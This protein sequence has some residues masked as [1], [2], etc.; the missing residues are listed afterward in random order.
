ME[1]NVSPE[2]AKQQVMMMV[3]VAMVLW[4]A[5]LLMVVAAIGLEFTELKPALQELNGDYT[6]AEVDGA[7]ADSHISDLKETAGYMPPMLMTLKLG[8]IGFI[9]SGIFITLVAIVRV[10][11]MMPDRLGAIIG[12]SD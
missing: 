7:E 2:Q 3:K 12:G 10:L 5:G 9:L 11:A 4:I 6:K 1:A 8:G